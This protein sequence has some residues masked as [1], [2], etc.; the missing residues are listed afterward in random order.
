MSAELGL[1]AGLL[2]IA[3]MVKNLA[4]SFEEQ[5]DKMHKA[6]LAFSVMFLIGMEYTAIGI[7]DTAGY[8]NAANVYTFTL[9]V[10]SL[11]FLGMMYRIIY[12][13]KEEMQNDSQMG[14]LGE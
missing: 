1:I 13:M 2:G 5:K 6:L 14:G 7:A 4:V 8:S 11:V 3:Y 10:T 9:I 12:Q